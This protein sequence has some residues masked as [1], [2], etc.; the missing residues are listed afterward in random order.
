MVKDSLVVYIEQ[1]IFRSIE[2]DAIVQCF[3]NMKIC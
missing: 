2:N 3:Q 1:D